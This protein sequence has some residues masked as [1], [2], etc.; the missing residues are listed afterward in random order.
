MMKLRN[1]MLRKYNA[2]DINTDININYYRM[3]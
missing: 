1:Y 2:N 3:I